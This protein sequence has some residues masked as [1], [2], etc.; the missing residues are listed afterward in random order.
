MIPPFSRHPLVRQYNDL[1]RYFRRYE[2][3]ATRSR[4]RDFRMFA[5]IIDQA[6]IPVAFDFL[7]SVNFGVAT[8]AS[9]VDL[10]VYIYCDDSDDECS[11]ETCYNRRY[12]EHLLLR[13]LIRE[14]SAIPYEVQTVDCVN[15]RHLDLELEK[16]DPNS[17]VL[18][19]FAFY[20]SICRCVNAR[21]LQPYQKRLMENHKLVEELQPALWTIFDGL[22][23]SSSHSWSLRKYRERVED[24]G[25]RLPEPIIQR[26]QE[27]LHLGSLH[28]G[29]QILEDENLNEDLNQS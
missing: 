2:T 16:A 22:S 3:W 19:K 15:L 29:D 13:T 26:I 21:L 28:L 27:H 1:K 25:V 10:V 7:G 11:P 5:R 14:Y 24:I 9:D 12:V 17:E 8:Q 23:R 18:L 20:R 4:I 6:G